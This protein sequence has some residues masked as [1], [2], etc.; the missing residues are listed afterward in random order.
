MAFS[1]GT[2]ALL[3]NT[4]ANPGFGFVAAPDLDAKD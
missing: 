1:T 2:Q 4:L 3:P